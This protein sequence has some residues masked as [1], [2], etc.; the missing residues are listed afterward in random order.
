MIR[1]NFNS[2]PK[3]NIMTNLGKVSEV[4][5]GVPAGNILDPNG[6]FYLA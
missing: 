1:R 5:L 3:G 4:T 2:N 6:T